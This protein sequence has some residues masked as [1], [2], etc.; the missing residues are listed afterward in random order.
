MPTVCFVVSDTLKRK[1]RR[2]DVPFA[3]ILQK[4]QSR[5]ARSARS[6][7]RKIQVIPSSLSTV[8]SLAELESKVLHY[9]R[10]DRH[11]QK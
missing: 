9:S 4:Q 1:G 8:L 5:A 7:A 11:H 3:T 2:C 6:S 10:A